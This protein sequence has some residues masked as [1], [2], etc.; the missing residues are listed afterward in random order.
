MLKLDPDEEDSA[1]EDLNKSKLNNTSTF[2]SDGTDQ[3]NESSPN[4]NNSSLLEN[5]TQDV[6]VNQTINNVNKVTYNKSNKV[7]FYYIFQRANI[8][9]KFQIRI[10]IVLISIFSRRFKELP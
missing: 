7:S 9:L 3:I 6:N 1:T 8:L 2:N 10:N 5:S 4:L